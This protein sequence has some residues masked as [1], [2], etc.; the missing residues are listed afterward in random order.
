V[1]NRVYRG[2]SDGLM[3]CT[4]SNAVQTNAPPLRIRTESDE[5]N[6]P[7]TSEEINER[8]D[9]PEYTRTFQVNDTLSISYAWVS[10]RGYYPDA[11]DKE[12]QDTYRYSLIHLL[13]Y[14]L[15]HSLTYSLTHL[16]TYSL[17]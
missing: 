15:T 10:Q 12:N 1:S 3:G 17:T 11:I 14:S 13:T 6:A 8:I 16:L 5:R 4:T 9:S 2:F 7:L